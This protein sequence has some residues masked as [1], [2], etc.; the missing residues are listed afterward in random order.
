[1]L[2]NKTVAA[3]GDLNDPVAVFDAGIGSYALVELIRRSQPQRDIIY[4]A[5]RASFPYG[6]KSRDQLLSIMRSTIQYLTSLGAQ[7]IVLASNAPSVMVLDTLKSEFAVPVYGVAPPVRT[8]LAASH[9]GK[10]AVMGVRSMI[11]SEELADFVRTQADNPGDVALIN[12][13]AMVELVENGAF[14]RQ[15]DETAQKVA[16][17]C[18][19]IAAS[20][21]LIDTLTLSSTHL[22]WLRP[23]FETARPGWQ[24]LDPADDVIAA[25]P[26]PEGGSGRTVALVTKSE[27]YPVAEF[28]HMLEIL[29]VD[30]PLTVIDP[31]FDKPV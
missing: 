18:D 26:Q 9:S 19:D 8:A 1:M 4:F 29:Q 27:T 11:E 25:L 13:S 15:P 20:Y 14:L 30:L 24:F 12:A 28:R 6:A 22:P 21:P 3:V 23:F 10:V 7:T 16:A 31:V 17:F 5:D 2:K